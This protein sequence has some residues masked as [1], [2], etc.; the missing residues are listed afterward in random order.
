MKKLFLIVAIIAAVFS[1]NTFV[2]KKQKELDNSPPQPISKPM[3]AEVRVEKSAGDRS[4]EFVLLAETIDINDC[5]STRVAMPKDMHT[6]CA[7]CRLKSS[8]CKADLEP[9]YAK[10]F[11]N[12]PTHLTYLS[13]GRGAQKERE[14]R[15]LTWGLSLEESNKLCELVPKFQQMVT[16]A[17]SCVRALN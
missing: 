14:M 8:E 15:L 2:A 6:A 11:K 13:I 12:Q 7:G 4:I 5:N 17:V 9:R 1:W 3:Y 16:G 10:L